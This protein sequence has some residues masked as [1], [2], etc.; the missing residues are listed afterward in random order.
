LTA[1]S[2]APVRL[3][4]LI[5]SLTVG[6]AEALVVP[7]ARRLDRRRF[8]L[9]VCALSTIAGNPI[10]SRLRDAGVRVVSLGARSLRDRSAFGRLKDF[11]RAESTDLVHA[12]L[13]YSAIW[14]ALLSRSTG[15]PSIITLHVAPAASRAVQTTVRQKI[16]TTVRDRLMRFAVNRWSSRVV[17]VSGALRD[18]YARGGGIRRSK[19]RVVHNGIEVERFE[20]DR[21][22]S[23][24][25]LA[26]EFGIPPGAPIV[27]T[28]SV[29]RPGK[30]VNV[31]LEAAREI[32]DAVFLIIGDGPMAAE[33]RQLAASRGVDARVRWAGHRD[34]VDALL[35]GCDLFAHP[36]LSDAF[37]TVL[38]EAMAAGLP[39]VAS[40]VGGVPEIV[41]PSETGL[42]VPPGDARKLTAA[43]ADL[44]SSPQ[45]ARQL[46][47]RA[48]LIARERFSI[49]AWLRNLAALYDEVLQ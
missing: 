21:A 24:S 17:M 1:G 13:A 31:L 45:R 8:D 46:G 48:R 40:N 36:T 37:P 14:S 12:H 44:L 29:L 23:R 49:D 27:V 28:V 15:I 38:L 47:E 22:E 35:A 3:L 43:I 6:G 4:W 25:R 5:D 33:W 32:P 9:T 20:R 16:L 19:I 41:V 18:N 34:D 30:G 11:V 7:F 2:S 39:I 26:R 10:E 42:L